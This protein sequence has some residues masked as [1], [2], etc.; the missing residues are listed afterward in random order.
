[1]RDKQFILSNL[2]EVLTSQ[3]ATLDQIK[4]AKKEVSEG[5]ELISEPGNCGCE[6]IPLT[7]FAISYCP[8]CGF[9]FPY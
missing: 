8:K 5:L 2:S 9:I 1:M 7:N 4:K 6:P 3:K